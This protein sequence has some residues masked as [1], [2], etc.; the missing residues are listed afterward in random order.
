MKPSV[1]RVAVPARH[2]P[3]RTHYLIRRVCGLL[4]FWL[5]RW[6]RVDAYDAGLRSADFTPVYRQQR[7]YLRPARRASVGFLYVATSTCQPV[8]NGLDPRRPYLA[9]HMHVTN[10]RRRIVITPGT[11]SATG[12]DTRPDTGPDIGPDIRPKHGAAHGTT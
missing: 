11:G 9:E 10:R 12:L 8:G 1:K 4:T 2:H 7:D 6:S 3:Q 5:D